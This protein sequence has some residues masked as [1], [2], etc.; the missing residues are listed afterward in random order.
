MIPGT[1][2]AEAAG[3]SMTGRRLELAL[4]MLCLLANLAH[5]G[6]VPQHPH[7]IPSVMQ[8]A[9]HRLFCWSPLERLDFSQFGW[10]LYFHFLAGVW[11]SKLKTIPYLFAGPETTR[12]DS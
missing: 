11:V 9:S 5:M 12:V 7:D 10:S 2:S 3:S 6:L 1:A 8:G 4:H